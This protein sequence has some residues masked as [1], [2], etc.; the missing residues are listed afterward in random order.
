LCSG[1]VAEKKGKVW[2][3]NDWGLR[4]L[5]YKI[6]KASKAN[7]VLMNI[8]IKASAIN[9]LNT[10][11]QKDERVI[12]HICI[13]QKE[14][15]TEASVPP[16]NYYPESGPDAEAQEGDDDEE[17]E[18]DDDDDEQEEE[19][20]EDSGS[21]VDSSEDEGEELVEGQGRFVRF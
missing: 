11:L 18:E 2:R 16:P 3:L 19:E 1:F 13:T 6:K 12:R 20:E 10:M 8:E 14:A 15:I 5:A 9:E 21:E 17:D 7:Y 4:R